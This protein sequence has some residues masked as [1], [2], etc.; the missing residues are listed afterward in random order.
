M[1]K[2][3]LI[4]I[5]A[6]V[7]VAGGVVAVVATN[8]AKQDS[9]EKVV[10]SRVSGVSTSESVVSNVVNT[11]VTDFS[12]LQPIVIDGVTQFY[13]HTLNALTTAPVVILKYYVVQ[14]IKEH[15][16]NA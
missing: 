2:K 15:I 10:N 4:G 8:S 13:D 3:I 9:N 16:R 12:K 6:C 11:P 1:D 7:V 5:L 14:Y